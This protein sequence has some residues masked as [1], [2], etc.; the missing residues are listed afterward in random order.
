MR[1]IVDLFRPL[2]AKVDGRLCRALD[3]DFAALEA[4]LAKY[5]N[6]DGVFEPTLSLTPD[7]RTTMQN[8]MKKLSGE[9][10]QIPTD[11]GLG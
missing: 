11:L 6:A 5:K 10:S 1:K 8:T 7:D 4:T 3:D 9:L 2:I